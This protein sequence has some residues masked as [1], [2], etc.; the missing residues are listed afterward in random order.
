[1]WLCTY[2][3]KH[4]I[5]SL[6]FL[7]LYS[8]SVTMISPLAGIYLSIAFSSLASALVLD[9]KSYGQ[10]LYYLYIIRVFGK[11]YHNSLY[12]SRPII[13]LKSYLTFYHR[14]PCGKARW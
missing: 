4:N 13:L 9:S 10:S 5:L 8:L 6:T 12:Q 11:I 14:H 3:F 7:H 2:L 1:M